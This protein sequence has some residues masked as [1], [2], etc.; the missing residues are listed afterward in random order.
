MRAEREL[1]L[2]IFDQDETKV[3]NDDDLEDTFRSGP[4]G[5]MAPRPSIDEEPDTGEM[6][7]AVETDAVLDDAGP[8]AKTHAVPKKV[9]VHAVRV[10]ERARVTKVEPARP[11]RDEAPQ[12][13]E[14]KPIP[15][16][17][18]A[19]KIEAAPRRK[20]KLKY[21]PFQVEDPPAVGVDPAIFPIHQSAPQ[22]HL[23]Q[24]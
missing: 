3:E 10:V 1:D 23:G 24:R 9:P 14:A 6:L 20:E 17:I 15:A 11:E 4:P 5:G 7:A 16:K 2:G 13:V 8:T 19:K 18:E 12:P 21:N 22:N